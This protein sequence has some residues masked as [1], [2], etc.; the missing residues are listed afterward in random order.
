MRESLKLG[1]QLTVFVEDPVFGG[2]QASL[3]AVG[4]DGLALLRL[5]GARGLSWAAGPAC[6]SRVSSWP[7][8]K[9]PRCFL[10]FF[11]SLL[12]GKIFLQISEHFVKV[13]WS[14]YFLH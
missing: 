8:T 7:A 10:L 11:L 6:S 3:E 13:L 4:P 1:N 14:V 2:L 5:G 12:F 9:I